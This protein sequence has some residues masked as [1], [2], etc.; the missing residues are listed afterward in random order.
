[1]IALEDG[2]LP[3]ER[4]LDDND[5]LEEERRLVF[6]GI[7]RGQQEVHVSAS[8]IRDYRGNKRIS[9]PS[10][11]LTEMLGKESYLA[12]PEAPALNEMPSDE[13]NQDEGFSTDAF[14]DYFSKD[15]GTNSENQLNEED[16]SGT[17]N[18]QTRPDGLVLEIDSGFVQELEP[19]R[20]L[21]KKECE[22][23]WHLTCMNHQQFKQQMNSI[24]KLKLISRSMSENGYFTKST[25]KAFLKK[26]VAQDTMS[27][28]TVRFE[29]AD[30]TRKICPYTRRTKEDIT[31]PHS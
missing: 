1:M 23:E 16:F 30:R 27:I 21:T 8:R 14:A 12:G 20:K 3:H 6:V 17:T 24:K 9:A 31:N 2:I 18:A 25:A 15:A 7:T 22:T 5:Q 13:H 11:F 28:G 4:S 19:N 29:G 10:V 26:L